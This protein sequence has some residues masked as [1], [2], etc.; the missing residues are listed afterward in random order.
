MSLHVLMQ[1]TARDTS[2]T[3]RPE[4]RLGREIANLTASLRRELA[5][6]AQI[7]QP[8]KVRTAWVVELTWS[9]GETVSVPVTRYAFNETARTAWLLPL[10]GKAFQAGPFVAAKIVGGLR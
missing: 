6:P 7:Q 4:S 8:E 10:D 9:N 2:E 1:Q 3:L 5:W